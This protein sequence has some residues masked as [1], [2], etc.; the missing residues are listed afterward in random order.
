[1]EVPPGYTELLQNFTVEVLRQ[2]P[3]DV[4]DFAV[5]YFT[6]LRDARRGVSRGHSLL[7]VTSGG[8]GA[9]QGSAT[10]GE[11]EEK[12]HLRQLSPLRSLRKIKTP[13]PLILNS[14]M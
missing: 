7:G 12:T 2:K 11:A 5:H 10:S 8:G 9:S 4:L 1:M 14:E 13:S 6:Q 3:P